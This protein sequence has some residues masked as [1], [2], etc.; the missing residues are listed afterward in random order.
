[1]RKGYSKP[2]EVVCN[3]EYGTRVVQKR[4]GGKGYPVYG[5]GGATFEMDK[6]NREDRLVV[7]RFGMSEE[8]TRFV[9]GKFFLNDSGLTVSPKNSEMLQ[10][11]L[12]LQLLSLND[13]IYA[14]GKGTAQKNLDVPVFRTLPLYVPESRAEQQRIVGILD[15]AFEGIATAKV[16][17]ERNLRN[18]S[19]IFESHL[20]ASFSQPAE[21]DAV[22]KRAIDGGSREDRKTAGDQRHAAASRDR[23]SVADSRSTKTGGRD[24]TLRHIRGDYSLSVGMPTTS[25][26]DGWQ[27]SSLS[28]L[29]R[30]ES[31]HTPSRKHSEYWGGTIP[32]LGIQDAREHHGGRISQTLQYTNELGIAN[33]SARVLP[34]NTVCLSRT[35]S[36]GYVV[37]TNA[38][39]ATSQDFVNWVCSAKL[40][41]DFLKYLILAEGRKGLLRFASGSVHQ[42]IY[43][44]EA[45][46]FHICH[47]SS[48]EQARIVA[49]LDAL[50]TATSRLAGAYSKKL[51]AIKLLK[52][53]MLHE[54]FSG[55][56]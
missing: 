41:P 51:V 11:F 38:P 28:E 22:A 52:Q 8:S 42:T 50:R 18:A 5:G 2:L 29:S 55:H 32:W 34:P 21:G 4:D 23:S 20:Q 13:D 45:K 44:P 14:I 27:W 1:M 26:K 30:L 39:M 54:A 12:D 36:V 49:K 56:L 17:A 48:K 15:E 16:N 43:F 10:R 35:A 7:A 31:G 33:S 37:V 6:F 46:A 19:A 47:P 9:V 3:V 53:S 40:N 24:A 25:P